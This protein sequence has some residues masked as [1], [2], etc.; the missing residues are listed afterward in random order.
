MFYNMLLLYIMLYYIISYYII[1][2]H[3]MY[4]IYIYIYIYIWVYNNCSKYLTAGVG[5]NRSIRKPR[6]RKLR[7]SESRFPGTHIVYVYTYIYIY[8]YIHLYIYIYVLCIY[9]ISL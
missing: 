3:S 6:I 8:M 4:Y 2:Y 5:R 1:V 9:L 7:T